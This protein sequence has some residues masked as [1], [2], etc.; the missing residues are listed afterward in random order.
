MGRP[1]LTIDLHKVEHNARTLVTLCAE[2]G[3]G[4]T[5]VTKGVCGLPEVAQAMLRGGVGSLGDSRLENLER[6][7]HAGIEAPLMMLR[8]PSLSRS[9]E[10]VELADLSLQSELAVLEAVSAAAL[11][12]GVR[13]PVIVMVDLGDLR[14]GVW[15]DDL[16]PFTR[17][18]L[19]FEDILLVGLGANLTCYGG[20][21]PTQAN[22]T[23]LVDCAEAVETTFGVQLAWL[24]GGNS[25]ALPLIAS[26]KMPARVNHVR[27][28]EAILLGRE[29]V[30]REAWPGTFPDAFVLHGEIIEL[31]C[32]PSVPL[33]PRTE[34]AFGGRPVFAERGTLA[35]ALVNLG[36]EDVDVNGLTPCDPRIR[37]L[38]ASSDYLVVDVTQAAAELRVGAT[39]SFQLNYAALLAAM[40]SFYVEKRFYDGQPR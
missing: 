2:H 20:V 38:G 34:D 4:V 22:M 19:A 24:S 33:G 1:S 6:L 40:D 28:G 14:E 5:G 10:V 27:I 12:R 30:H 9:P 7:R 15:P 26:G 13:H 23:R 36:R 31:K 16:I 18:L 37:V 11:R 3:I 39:L 29:T 17:E 25:S 21:I 32:K 8:V 35:H